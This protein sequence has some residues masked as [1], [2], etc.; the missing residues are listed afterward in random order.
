MD[1][2]LFT[3]S[4]QQLSLPELPCFTDIVKGGVAFSVGASYD[5]QHRYCGVAPRHI[6][7]TTPFF[8]KYRA[9]PFPPPLYM[10]SDVGQSTIQEHCNH[11]TICVNQTIRLCVLNLLSPLCQLFLNKTGNKKNPRT[12][13][14]CCLLWQSEEIRDRV[15]DRLTLLSW[16]TLDLAL[17]FAS[18]LPLESVHHVIGVA[19]SSS[20]FSLTL[21]QNLEQ[22]VAWGQLVKSSG[23]VSQEVTSGLGLGCRLPTHPGTSLSVP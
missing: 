13:R 2:M 22:K 23:P 5:Q 7:E 21:Q 14:K 3:V 6:F 10:S 12:L 20:F 16:P 15:W 9:S 18:C 1:G 8:K 4:E 11:F 19:I 17:P